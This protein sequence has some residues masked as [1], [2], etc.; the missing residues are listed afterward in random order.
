MALFAGYEM[1]IQYASVMAE[2]RAVREHAGMFDVSHMARLE[3]T[4]PNT[5][6][7]LQHVT[8]NDVDRL[9]D[10]AGQY[11]LL[12]NAEGGCI[13]DIIVTRLAQDRFALVVNA[14]NHAKDLDWLQAQAKP[15]G[16]EIQDKTDATAML[17]VQGPNAVA[18]VTNL[19][20]E[21]GLAEIPPFGI[22]NI[23]LLG[24]PATASRTGY[25]G[26][27]GFELV[28]PAEAAVPLWN[29]LREAG[30]E[31]CGLAARD[32][33]R[34][35]AGLPLYGHELN[36]TQ[37]PLCA[38][39]GWVISKS[40]LFVGSEIL[41]HVRE[42]GVPEKLVGIKLATKRLIPIGAEVFVSDERVGAVTSGVVSPTLDCGIAFAFVQPGIPLNSAAEV[43][44]RGKREPATVVG[45]RFL[46]NPKS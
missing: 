18:I 45:K 41:G 46:K 44:L 1:P 17:A 7:F 34:V 36:E 27:D 5:L 37:S 15:F 22:A 16:V 43:D 13:D 2:A 10:G 8:S 24:Y 14:A 19:A 26:E 12:P 9:V 35:E 42:T 21:P 11:S 33:L 38:G 23:R 28:A 20:Q 25:T 40:K 4:G 30:V 39:L 32:T 3:L 29:A 6:D 31:P